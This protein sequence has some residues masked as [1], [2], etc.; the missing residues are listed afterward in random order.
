[1]SRAEVLLAQYAHSPPCRGVDPS[2]T[3]VSDSC[4]RYSLRRTRVHHAVLPFSR[5]TST[6]SPVPSAYT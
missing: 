4:W 1:M 5:N 3:S 6:H 2:L